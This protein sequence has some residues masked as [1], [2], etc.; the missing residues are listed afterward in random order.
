MKKKEREHL[1][2]DPFANF[3]QLVIEKFHKLKREIMIILG[4][5]GIITVIIIAILLLRS[6]TIS[7]DN[8]IYSSA[9]NIWNSTELTSDQKIEK[10]SSLKIG[11]GISSATTFYIA[12]LQYEKGDYEKAKES[13]SKYKSGNKLLNDQKKLLESEILFAMKEEKKGMDIL[14][15]LLSDTKSE[16]TKDFLLLRIAK[17]N[18]KNGLVRSAKD[19]LNRLLSEF[20]QSIYQRDARQLMSKLSK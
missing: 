3:I 1:K 18:I 13:L 11:K 5:L 8:K 7:K 2:E 9:L 17:I 19:N 4:T 20:P 6:S 10:L 12:S 16:I 14:N 15:Q